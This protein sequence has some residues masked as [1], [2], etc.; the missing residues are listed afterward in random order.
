MTYGHTATESVVAA[1]AGTDR[2]TGLDLLLIEE[3]AAYFR[4][5][6]KK[7]A[8][9]EGAMRGIEISLRLQTGYQLK[10]VVRGQDTGHVFNGDGVRTHV[11]D[12][13]GQINP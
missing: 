1:M 5:V 12:A 11:F 7:Y 13:L 10:R 2:D 3:I 8:K 4:E 9:F 6:R